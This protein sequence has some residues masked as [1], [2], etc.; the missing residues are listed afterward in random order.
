MYSWVQVAHGH[1]GPV[2][3]GLRPHGT[4]VHPGLSARE[5]NSDCQQSI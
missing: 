5:D 3:T 2:G 1:L 4:A